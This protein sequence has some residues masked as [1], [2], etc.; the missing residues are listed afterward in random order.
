MKLASYK[1]YGKEHLALIINHQ[2]YDVSRLY[3]KAPFNMQ[4]L[5]ERWD[6]EYPR[7]LKE[8]SAILSGEKSYHV[9]TPLHK[10]E[11]LAPVPHPTSCRD[12]Y[13]FR[14]HVAAARRNRNAT[15][16]PEFDE[17]PVFYFT[18]HHSIKGP[19]DI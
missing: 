1:K 17:Y 16:L 18:N 6:D 5:L 4:Q 8:E 19:D 3:S 10:A 12:A 7:L 14:Q 15:M 11:L 2:L 13:A 9:S